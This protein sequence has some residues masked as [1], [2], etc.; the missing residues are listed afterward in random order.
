M[1]LVHKHQEWLSVPQMRLTSYSETR[2]FLV[3][4]PWGDYNSLFWPFLVASDCFTKQLYNPTPAANCVLGGEQQRED[5]LKREQERIF[6]KCLV[7]DWHKYWHCQSSILI[8]RIKR[9]HSLDPDRQR[10]ALV[11]GVKGNGAYSINR[12]TLFVLYPRCTASS[13]SSPGRHLHQKTVLVGYTTYTCKAW[14]GYVSMV[15]FVSNRT[16]RWKVFSCFSPSIRIL[17][18]STLD[19]N[20]RLNKLPRIHI[21]PAIQISWL[22]KRIQE[23]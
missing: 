6:N 8:C 17:R 10:W 13:L 15:Y 2:L 3:V 14:S 16:T 4:R 7:T 12:I 23:I 5:D 1:V 20:F 9:R 21:H 18:V 11:L 19:F 22:K